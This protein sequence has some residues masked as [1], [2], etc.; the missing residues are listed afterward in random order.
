M[1][2]CVQ[3]KMR[4]RNV[5]EV[6]TVAFMHAYNVQI[7]VIHML[8]S[9][10]EPKHEMTDSLSKCICTYIPCTP[11]F[12]L[13]LSLCCRQNYHKFPSIICEQRIIL[14]IFPIKMQKSINTF[15]HHW[16]FNSKFIEKVNTLAWLITSNT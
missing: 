11:F 4:R 12:S 10:L 15:F 2:L 7:R 6:A 16:E 14:S 13:S 3:N 8:C 5:K 1:L 9:A